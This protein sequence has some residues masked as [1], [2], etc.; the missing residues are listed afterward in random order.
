MIRLVKRSYVHPLGSDDDRNTSIGLIL[1]IQELGQFLI[2]IFQSFGIHLTSIN[3]E[4]S[5]IKWKLVKN[6]DVV[7]P[8]IKL[9]VGGFK[10]EF[11]SSLLILFEEVDFI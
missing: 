10:V 4:D 6:N 2:R 3:L 9:E 5:M 11:F 7:L 8:R 1:K